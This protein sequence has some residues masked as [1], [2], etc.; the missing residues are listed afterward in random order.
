[1]KVFGGRGEKSEFACSLLCSI[2]ASSNIQTAF[3]IVSQRKQSAF[4]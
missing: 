1:M 3:C 4:L 2:P